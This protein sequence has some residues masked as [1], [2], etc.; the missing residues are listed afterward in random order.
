MEEK[1]KYKSLTIKEKRRNDQSGM[2]GERD[3]GGC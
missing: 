2:W 1:N 3:G